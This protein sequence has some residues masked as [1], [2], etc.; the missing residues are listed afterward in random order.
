MGRSMPSLARR[1]EREQALSVNIDEVVF[2][3]GDGRFS[4]LKGT[5]ERSE[6]PVTLVGDLGAV[7]PGETLAVRGRFETHK[8]YGQ[9]F[10]VESF[11]PVTPKT[12]EGIKRYLGSGLVAGIGPA[13]AERLVQRFGDQTLEVI[14]TQS[15]R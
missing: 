11:T 2:Q 14:T 9:R 6:E 1:M 15:A 8:S 5:D 3:S 13:I 12:R 7:A 4:V 10:R